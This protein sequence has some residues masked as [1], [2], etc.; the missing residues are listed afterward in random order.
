MKKLFTYVIMLY[1]SLSVSVAQQIQYPEPVLNPESCTSI[2]V[3]KKASADGSVMTS[4]TCDSNYRTWMDIVPSAS[5][6]HDTTTTVY[7]GRMH[8][9]YAEGTRGMIAKGTLPEARSTYQFLN[10]AYPCLNEKQLGI[11]ETTITGR[12]AL[13]NKKG[14][15]MIEELQRIALQRCT[16]ARDAIRLMGELIEKYGYGDW[17]AKCRMKRLLYSYKDGYTTEYEEYLVE[18]GEVVAN[19]GPHSALVLGMRNEEEHDWLY[20]L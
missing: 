18:D 3:G 10:T 20:I 4:H 17:P 6:D 16:T 5:Y 2:M 7:T 11:G 1:A 12:K 8:T 19:M 14:M 13:V 15:F 9:E